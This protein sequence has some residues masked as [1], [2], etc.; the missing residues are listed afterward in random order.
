MK[1]DEKSADV[2]EL[3]K[4][5]DG[6]CVMHL[7]YSIHCIVESCLMLTWLPIQV[8]FQLISI[9]K[10]DCTPCVAGLFVGAKGL[11]YFMCDYPAT[12]S[13]VI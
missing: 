5:A 2:L 7:R 6:M 12:F 8:W 10:L 9:K 13:F 1:L 4:N 11:F 3:R